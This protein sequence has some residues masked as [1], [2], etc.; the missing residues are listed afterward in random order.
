[1]NTIRGWL[2][3]NPVLA[4]TAALQ[5]TLAIFSLIAM[6]FDHRTILGI[7]PWIK[8]L[9]FDV[10]VCIMLVTLAAI[11]S[12]LQ[13]FERSRLWIGAGVGISLSI[14]NCIISLQLLRGVRSHMNYST[15]LDAHL[16]ECMA[17]FILISTVLFVW[18]LGLVVLDPTRWAPAVA[19]GV[20]LGL[21]TLLAGSLEG[22]LMVMHG[23]HTVGANDGLSGLP[24]VNWS[25]DHGD[26]RIAHFFAL[27]A[28][29]AFPLLGWLLSRT[30]A[31]VNQQVVL[32]CIGVAVYLGAVWLLF[33]QAMAGQ[34]LLRT[35]A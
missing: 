1:M 22:V 10:S 18:T 14:E 17:V 7:N 20:R 31:P 33:H 9:K 23:G 16:F 12:G 2:Q 34:P 25:R 35:K 32:T 29:Q 13:G 3:Q 11:L 26:L 19:W 6:P 24:L 28:L 30:S 15:P 4:W 27:H 21:V 8:P 5:V